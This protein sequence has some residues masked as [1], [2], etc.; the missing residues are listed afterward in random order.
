MKLIKKPKKE[1]KENL[2][3]G[4]KG[5]LESNNKVINTN[6]VIKEN[7]KVNGAGLVSFATTP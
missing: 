1:L 4:K 5:T 2:T 7:S 3:C 6:L